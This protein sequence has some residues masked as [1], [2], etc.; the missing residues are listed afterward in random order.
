MAKCLNPFYHKE[1]GMHLPCGRCY[2]CL[3][4]RSSGWSFRLMNTERYSSSAFFVTLTYDNDHVPLTKRGFMTLDKTHVPLFMKRLRFGQ[5]GRNKGDIKY[6]MCG[7][8]GGLS[9]RPHYHIIIFNNVL[10]LLIGK[11]DANFTR[12]NQLELDGKVPYYSP[13]WT[14]AKTG[15]FRGHITVGAVNGASV[16]YTLKYM[17]KP[18]RIPF[19]HKD[20]RVREYA[21]MSKGL[22]IMYL[23]NGIEKWH[24]ADIINR[25]YCNLEDGVKIAM[26]RYYKDKL[27]N[28]DERQEILIHIL[29]KLEKEE[30]S[31]LSRKDQYRLSQIKLEISSTKNR[32]L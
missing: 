3:M 16:G 9:Y 7:E 15:E 25:M 28:E 14:D 4:R 19:H 27:Y 2:N 11:K 29:K 10:D 20:D 30:P 6:Y 8:Y 23:T 18:K 13:Y 26:P 5:Y 21:A 1:I 31:K 22:G 32:K 17:N 12:I 24:K